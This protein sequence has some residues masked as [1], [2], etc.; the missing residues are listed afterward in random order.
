MTQISPAPTHPS[1]PACIVKTK[2]LT[3]CNEKQQVL[4]CNVIDQSFYMY[5]GLF[6]LMWGCLAL[7]NN[8][9]GQMHISFSMRAIMFT[10]DKSWTICCYIDNVRWLFCLTHHAC[11]MSQNTCSQ[12]FF[13]FSRTVKITLIRSNPYSNLCLIF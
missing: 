4:Q 2:A 11:Y 12:Y 3:S 5:N 1:E 8:T 13:L 10:Y 7:N 9:G 6:D